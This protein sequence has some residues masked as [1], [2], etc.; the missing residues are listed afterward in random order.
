MDV[1]VVQ[2]DKIDNFINKHDIEASY[3]EDDSMVTS[4]DSVL[5]KNEY[6]TSCWEECVPV[7]SYN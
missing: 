5:R 7:L 1:E 3:Q 6:V 2:G 4:R